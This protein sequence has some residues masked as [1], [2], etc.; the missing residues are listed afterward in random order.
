M[1]RVKTIMNSVTGKNYSLDLIIKGRYYYVEGVVNGKKVY[2][3][4]MH[5]KQYAEDHFSNLIQRAVST[6]SVAG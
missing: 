5:K 4:P 3:F 6:T 2:S 1:D